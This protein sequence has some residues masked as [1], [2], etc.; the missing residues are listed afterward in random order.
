[1]IDLVILY[2]SMKLSTFFFFIFFISLSLSLSI[3]LS[4]HLCLCLALSCSVSP[5]SDAHFSLISH[6]KIMCLCT[7]KF[8]FARRA[9]RPTVL[10]MTGI[11]PLHSVLWWNNDWPSIW[12]AGGY[13][14]PQSHEWPNISKQKL[15]FI[16]RFDKIKQ[17][18][19][20]V[21]VQSPVCTVAS[22]DLCMCHRFCEP[23]H[24]K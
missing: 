1:M 18:F 14:W 19:C 24:T 22:V 7:G 4:W 2:S 21:R 10:T 11:L 8:H 13:W 12:V 6:F 15:S 17:S 3:F 20:I 23:F 5:C 9:S 16:L